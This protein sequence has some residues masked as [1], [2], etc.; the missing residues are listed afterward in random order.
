MSDAFATVSEADYARINAKLQP[1]VLTE[2]AYIALEE[3]ALN[4]ER[5]IKQRTPVKTGNLQRS[6]TSDLSESRAAL[7]V[8]RVWTDVEYANPVESWAMMFSDGAAAAIEAAGDAV[9]NVA[10]MIEKR[11]SE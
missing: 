6:I 1:G 7:A 9:A 4:A 2:D 3:L 11:W 10:V 8:T 5:E